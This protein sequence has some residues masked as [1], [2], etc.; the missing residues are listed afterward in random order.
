MPTSMRKSSSLVTKK[1]TPIKI[2]VLHLHHRI[3]TVMQQTKF[4]PF[5]K[6]KRNNKSMLFFVVSENIENEVYTHI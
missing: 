3:S 2:N 6:V 5:K 4:F 1:F